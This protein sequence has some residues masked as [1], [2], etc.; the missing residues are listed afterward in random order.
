MTDE[1]IIIIVSALGGLIGGMGMGGGTLLIPLL[2]M[3]SGVEQHLAQ[4]INLIV[5]VPMSLVALFIHRKNGYVRLK[6]G[7]PIAVFAFAGAVAGSFATGFAKGY[8]LRAC[9]GGFLIALGVYQAAK[10][11]VAAVKKHRTKSCVECDGAPH[12]VK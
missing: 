6:A 3:C 10:I 2:T 7:A 1:H 9:F 4:S 5:F 12:T 11:T 8:I